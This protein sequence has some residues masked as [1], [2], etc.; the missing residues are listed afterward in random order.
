MQL[1]RLINS[2][3]HQCVERREEGA[4]TRREG[5]KGREEAEA[6]AEAG[7]EKEKGS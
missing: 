2:T 1:W 4:K 6:E 3:Q 5:G 7:E